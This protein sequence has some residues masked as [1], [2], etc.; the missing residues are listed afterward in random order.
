MAEFHSPYRG[1]VI[2][3]EPEVARIQFVDG[4]FS[5]SDKDQI[6]LIRSNGGFNTHIFEVVREVPKVEEEVEVEEDVEDLVFVCPVEGCGAEF[7]TKAQLNGHLSAH[8]RKG[9]I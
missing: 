4:V 5:T 8:K 9:E 1:L 2:N 3:A 7:E 6:E